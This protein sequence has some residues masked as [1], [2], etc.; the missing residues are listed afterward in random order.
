MGCRWRRRLRLRPGHIPR[1]TACKGANT[2]YSKN[3]E[4]NSHFEAPLLLQR[5]ICHEAR[6]EFLSREKHAFIISASFNPNPGSVL[7]RSHMEVLP[8]Y[9]AEVRAAAKSIVERN[10]TDRTGPL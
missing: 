6:G 4:T 2:N 8:K 7:R 3:L 1:E 9:L 10:F 5:L